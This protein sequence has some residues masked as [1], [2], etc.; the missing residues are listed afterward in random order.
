[1]SE[2]LVYDQTET[3][4]DEDN[5]FHRRTT[6]QGEKNISADKLEFERSR[7]W[8]GFARAAVATLAVL[9]A[10]VMV[11]I[12]RQPKHSV[13]VS[14]NKVPCIPFLPMT[15]VVMHC[16]LAVLIPAHGWLR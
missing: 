9:I 14:K 13:A 5:P 16:V 3:L 10:V 7:D 2:T 6:P 4:S 11:F 15:S 12:A 1:V 8:T